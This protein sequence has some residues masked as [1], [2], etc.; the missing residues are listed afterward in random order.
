MTKLIFVIKRGPI[1]LVN[2]FLAVRLV[3][4][5]AAARNNIL[6]LMSI[7]IVYLNISLMLRWP[8]QVIKTLLAITRKERMLSITNL[9]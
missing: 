9:R 3:E 2:E 4:S 5:A 6:S 7:I 1:G 8:K